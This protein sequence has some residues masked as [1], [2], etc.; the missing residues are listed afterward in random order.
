[1]GNFLTA[2]KVSAELP[3]LGPM[4]VHQNLGIILG[5]TAHLTG[6]FLLLKFTGDSTG[7]TGTV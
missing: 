6:T 1:M 2:P 5:P 4:F 3:P 7:R